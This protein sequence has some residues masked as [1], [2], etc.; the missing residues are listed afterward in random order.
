MGLLGDPNCFKYPT[1]LPKPYS[2]DP[3]QWI[4]HGH[5]AKSVD[6]LHLEGESP[7]DIFI[8]WKSVEQQPIGWEPD[9]NDGVRLNIRPFM[10]VPD[11][12]KKGSGVLRDKPGIDWKKDRGRDVSS[13]PWYH[14]FN[15]DRFNDH[16]LTLA[17][18]LAPMAKD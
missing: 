12:R 7:Y 6:P 10:S 18:K 5:P 15:G 11:I 3:T 8:R 13:A 9:I 4:F 16:H 14:V 1:G 2:D 17:G